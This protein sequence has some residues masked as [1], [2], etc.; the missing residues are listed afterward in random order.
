M[1]RVS[2][3]RICAP[4][5]PGPPASERSSGRPLEKNTL[6]QDWDWELMKKSPQQMT[7]PEIAHN[8]QL[9][10]TLETPEESPSGPSSI[11]LATGIE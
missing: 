5:V 3:L 6:K 11:L 9:L 1:D 8:V 7:R 2:C 4:S 10:K